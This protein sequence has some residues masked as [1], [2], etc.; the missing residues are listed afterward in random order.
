MNRN[1]RIAL[2]TARPGTSQFQRDTRLCGS[3]RTPTA[4]NPEWASVALRRRAPSKGLYDLREHCER[5]H[6]STSEHDE[7][8][9]CALTPSPDKRADL[10]DGCRG[11]VELAANGRGP[12]LRSEKAQTVA[13]TYQC[14]WSAPLQDHPQFL[15]LTDFAE[16][17]EDPVQDLAKRSSAAVSHPV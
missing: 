12:R 10:P 16:A 4:A 6:Q 14:I 17:Q 8:R 7:W 9:R 1:V 15:R 13:R 2:N 11:A 3:E 5:A